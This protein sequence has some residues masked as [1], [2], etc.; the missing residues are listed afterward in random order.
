VGEHRVASIDA[1]QLGVGARAAQ[2]DEVPT[3]AGTDLGEAAPPGLARQIPQGR[4]AAEEIVLACR[5]VEAMG[6][7]VVAIE[8][9]AVLG[10]RRRQCSTR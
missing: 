7:A 10:V 5:V 1:A 6:H 3:G 9:V 8:E 4:I 2:S